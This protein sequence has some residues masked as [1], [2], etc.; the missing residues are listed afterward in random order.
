MAR[1]RR[2]KRGRSTGGLSRRALLA[3]LGLGGISTASAYET[4]AFDTVAGERPFDIATA[5]DD[6]ALL[7]VDIQGGT[8]DDGDP[9]TLLTLTNRFDGPLESISASIVSPSSVPVDAARLDVP[10]RL[11][12]G[13]SAPITVP[14][15]CSSDAGASVEVSITA[16]G[17]DESV[18]L[19]RSVPVT[20]QVP[21]RG[22]CDPRSIP[23]A[24]E[25]P[26]DTIEDTQ[27][28]V[29]VLL[30]TAQREV[31]I[32]G[33]VTIRGALDISS[34]GT[35][36][37]KYRGNASVREYFRIEAPN[38]V[39]LDARNP[40]ITNGPL[41]IDAGGDATVDINGKGNAGI[42]G[43][44]CVKAGGSADVTL[45]NQTIEGD[46]ELT[47]S[48]V[49]VTIKNTTVEGDLTVGL[50]GEGDDEDG[51]DDEDSEGDEDGSSVTISGNSTVEGDFRITGDSE[52][53]SV[54][55]CSKVRGQTPE[56]CEDD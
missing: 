1:K 52:D 55:G 45:Q 21:S 4:G 7:G 47:A 6:E 32:T 51:G 5:D 20:C 40:E 3:A 37:V 28:G 39:T 34:S 15:A 50:S 22:V 54:S 36:T 56:A 9:V 33:N 2:R 13:E 19:T 26:V 42:G 17:P 41:Q 30:D 11:N 18:E 27:D 23:P 53:I 8:G 16:S 31:K 48:T 46:L 38:D 24:D 14:L 12:P 10:T 43:G 44:Q 25:G 35:I 29:S 49:D